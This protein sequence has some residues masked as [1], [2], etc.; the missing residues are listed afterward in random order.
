[1]PRGAQTPRQQFRECPCW[2]PEWQE[3]VL[4][5]ITR[6]DRKTH[7]ESY[8]KSLLREGNK[9]KCSCLSEVW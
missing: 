5:E 4:G 7:N 6:T 8:F 9:S 1:M 3:R 2:R